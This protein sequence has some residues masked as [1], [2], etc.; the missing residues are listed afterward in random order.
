M[1]KN[2]RNANVTHSYVNFIK[3]FQIIRKLYGLVLF[4]KKIVIA[5]RIDNGYDRK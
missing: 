4:K 1:E 5:G 3:G 2:N